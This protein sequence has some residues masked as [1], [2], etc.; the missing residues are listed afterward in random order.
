MAYSKKILDPECYAIIR[1]KLGVGVAALPDATLDRKDGIELGET[2]IIEAVPDYVDLVGDDK[3]YLYMA[4]IYCVVALICPQVAETILRSETLG[5]YRYENFPQNSGDKQK[6]FWD[7][8]NAYLGKI[9]T[10]V[11]GDSKLVEFMGGVE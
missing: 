1:D 5:D 2:L 4:T 6:S 11:V 3:T 10:Y 9:S 7:E 8:M